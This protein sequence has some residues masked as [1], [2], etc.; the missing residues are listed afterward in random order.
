M[1]LHVVIVGPDAVSRDVCLP[2]LSP[3]STSL[4]VGHVIEQLCGVSGHSKT[5]APLPTGFYTAVEHHQLELVAFS[6][7]EG[8]PNWRVRDRFPHIEGLNS[9][10]GDVY[11]ALLNSF[12]ENYGYH[13]LNSIEFERLFQAPVAPELHGRQKRRTE[14]ERLNEEAQRF[15]SRSHSR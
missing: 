15:M 14:A 13:N 10:N 3:V 11:F 5:L 4:E 6:R 7:D 12:S 9:I 2:D 1:I 8:R